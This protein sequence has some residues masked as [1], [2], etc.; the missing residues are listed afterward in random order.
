MDALLPLSPILS[1]SLMAI[2]RTFIRYHSYFI[3]P[4]ITLK[5]YIARWTLDVHIC[6][7]ANI[8]KTYRVS[9][10]QHNIDINFPYIVPIQFS[11]PIFLSLL[12]AAEKASNIHRSTCSI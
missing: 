8:V 4:A 1:L 11:H 3:Q 7:R 10:I 9:F 5:M 6:G 2:T 12:F